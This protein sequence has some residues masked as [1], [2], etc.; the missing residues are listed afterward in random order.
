VFNVTIPPGTQHDSRFR[1]SNQG[2]WE[3]G[4]AN[5]G[6]LVVRVSIGV[7]RNLT[8]EQRDLLEKVRAGL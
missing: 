8:Q 2:L 5:R 4:Q 1:I 7:P 3:P 6:H